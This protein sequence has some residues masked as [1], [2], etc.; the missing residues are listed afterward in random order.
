MREEKSVNTE[1]MKTI[2]SYIIHSFMFFLKQLILNF[3]KPLICLK[4]SQNK[5]FL[6]FMNITIHVI[7]VFK[8]KYYIK[9]NRLLG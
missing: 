3:S 6:F 5:E 4:S 9:N 7:F 1:F 2:L 8:N